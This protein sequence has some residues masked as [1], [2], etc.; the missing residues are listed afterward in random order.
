MNLVIPILAI[1]GAVLALGAAAPLAERI[2]LQ[3]VRAAVVLGWLGVLGGA[4]GI[5][6]GQLSGSSVLLG[7][8]ASAGLAILP[9]GMKLAAARQFATALAGVIPLI[10]GVFGLV[11]RVDIAGGNPG[12]LLLH[13]GHWGALSAALVAALMAVGLSSSEGWATKSER[14]TPGTSVGVAIAALAVGAYIIG[15]LRGGPEGISWAVPLASDAG[16]V[17]WQV[18]PLSALPQGLWIEAVANLGWMSPLLLA[19]AALALLTGIATR[20]EAGRRASAL[21]W[22]VSGAVSLAGLAGLLTS[23]ANVGLPDATRYQETALNLIGDVEGAQMLV[24][25]GSFITDGAVFV[26]LG[27]VAPELAMLA[28]AALIGA[29]AGLFSLRSSWPA[30]DADEPNRTAMALYG[31]D[32]ALR[33]VVLGWLGW[34]LATLIHWNHFGAVGVGSPSEWS[35]VGLLSVATG[36]LLLGWTRREGR[37]GR[38]VRGLVPGV[39]FG[40][41]VFGIA[42]GVVFD[43]PFGVSIVF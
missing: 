42:L 11:L 20:F 2:R 1:F 38:I 7:T 29:L 17:V 28:A 35:A 32:Y 26:P 33:A 3:L 15:S 39:I 13:A 40:L 34:L 36:V 31:R 5:Y 30:G 19:T 25:Q 21:G 24:R 22:F 12:M 14:K 27:E 41:L 16:G 10:L 23:R 18:P 6:T 9:V 37:V 8:A 4:V 43:A